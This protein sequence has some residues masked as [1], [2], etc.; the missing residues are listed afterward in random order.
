MKIIS[1]KLNIPRYHSKIFDLYFGDKTMAIFDIETTGLFAYRDKII[2]SGIVMVRGEKG[3]VIQYFLDDEGD[4]DELVLKT[5]EKLSEA[6]IVI[7]YNGR[8]FD[9]P[10]LEKRA[11]KFGIEM[12]RTFN[13]DLYTVVKNFSPLG[14]TLGSLNQKNLE[15][16][17][18]LDDGRSDE[19]SGYE[20]IKLYDRYMQSRSLSDEAK[21]LLHNHDDI[22]QLYKLLPV[23]A[24]CDLNKALCNYGFPTRHSVI[25]NI[26]ISKTD[27]F[28]SAYANEAITD[29]ISFPIGEKPYRIM[30]NSLYSLIE[31]EIPITHVGNEETGDISIIDAVSVLGYDS[32]ENFALSQN[33]SSY[34]GFES[35][36]LI[37]RQGKSINYL[38]VNLFIKELLDKLFLERTFAAD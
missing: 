6:D 28:I 10:F 15:I 18:G 34:P 30:S 33:L 3:E 12:P 35:G 31:I 27:L 37:L 29:Y 14:N 11:K 36:Y 2:L 13:L 23:L 38:A 25:S 24:Q 4:E 19:I 5:I 21:I 32:L 17:M 9:M 1:E 20:S 16:Y 8:S 7:T 22:I 26:K